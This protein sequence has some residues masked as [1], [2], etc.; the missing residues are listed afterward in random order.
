MIAYIDGEFQP[1]EMAKISIMDRGFLYG[2]GA[3]TTIKV[4]DGIPQF[5]ERHRQRISLQAEFLHIQMPSFTVELVE[6]LIEKNSAQKG[7]YKLKVILTGG[8]SQ[9]MSLKPR[10]GSLIVILSDYHEE[11]APA[12]QRLGVYPYPIVTPYAR[13]K[14]LSYLSRLFIKQ[15]A[16]YK[17]YDDMLV[18]DDHG[19]LLE[20]STANILWIKGK[21]LFTP[22]KELPLLW[23]ITLENIIEKWISLGYRVH[24]VKVLHE[25]IP[26]EASVFVTN[27]LKGIIPVASID[28]NVY[29]TASQE[30]M[31]KL[32]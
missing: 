21:E 26:H 23:G 8:V 4:Q 19:Y 31:K 3:F 25:Q 13:I 7:V 12:F 15:E 1:I 18:L 10:K 2:D 28:N 11:L 24:E 32:C 6:N 14:S 5:F 20:T 27:S 17:Q 16:F 9:E 22:S 30:L 29:S